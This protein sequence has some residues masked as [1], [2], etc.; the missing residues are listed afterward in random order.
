MLSAQDIKEIAGLYGIC[1]EESTKEER[2]ALLR[3]TARELD[4]E[5]DGETQEERARAMSA[6]LDAWTE[7]LRDL[8][9]R[10]AA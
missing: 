6:F 1:W 8:R 9:T 4:W 5:H 2:L 7:A 3:R 10:A